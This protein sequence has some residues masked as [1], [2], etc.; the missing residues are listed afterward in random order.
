MRSNGAPEEESWVI[1]AR[2]SR[3]RCACSRSVFRSDARGSLPSTVF[4]S[5]RE[6][7]KIVDSGVPSSCAAAAA[8]PSSWVKCCSRVSTSSVAASAS[9]SLR[10]SSVAWNAY[11]LVTPIGSTIGSAPPKRQNGRR[12]LAAQRLRILRRGSLGLGHGSAAS[13]QRLPRGPELGPERMRTNGRRIV[14]RALRGAELAEEVAGGLLSPLLERSSEPRS[15]AEAALQR[16]LNGFARALGGCTDLVELRLE[17]AEARLQGIDSGVA[18]GEL[19]RLV[20]LDDE[21]REELS[22]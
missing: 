5:S 10:A 2:M 3:Q 20:D 14:V 11:R 21:A 13:V 15:R 16:C 1:L 19:A 7:R 6:I 9:E 18:L 8:R 12:E 22:Q 4:S 17:I